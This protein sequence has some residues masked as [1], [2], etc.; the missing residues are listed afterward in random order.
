[1]TTSGSKPRGLYHRRADAVC[2]PTL[3]IYALVPPAPDAETVALLL[4]R[5]S[6]GFYSLLHLNLPMAD[7]HQSQAQ[8]QAIA[9]CTLDKLESLKVFAPL[10]GTREGRAAFI[11][12]SGI[13]KTIT[14]PSHA[15][16]AAKVTTLK[17]LHFDEL[18]DLDLG[19][20]GIFAGVKSDGTSSILQ[21]SQDGTL[22]VLHDWS[23]IVESPHFSGFVDRD[24]IVHVSRYALSKVLRVRTDT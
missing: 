2:S 22:S 12:T 20:H 24:G 8:V 3:Q 13:I 11:N 19:G 1:M 21:I 10:A 14:F 9:D 7:A 4:F 5:R 15:G 16:T 18:R 6:T 17:S 23:D